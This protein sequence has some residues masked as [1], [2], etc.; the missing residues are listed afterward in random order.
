MTDTPIGLVL[1]TLYAP[2]FPIP[3]S[4]SLERCFAPQANSMEVRTFL[5]SLDSNRNSIEQE[6]QCSTTQNVIAACT[7]YVPKVT[8]LMESINQHVN[9]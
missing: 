9:L 3:S 2:P 8:R 4:L 7:E 5:V 1:L 6:I